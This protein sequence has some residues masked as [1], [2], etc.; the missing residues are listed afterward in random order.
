MSAAL[1]DALP[2]GM[3]LTGT[4]RP[5]RTARVTLTGLDD[6]GPA[7][8][9]LVPLSPGEVPSEEPDV[10]LTVSTIELCRLASNRRTI[11]ELEL[12]VE[13]DRSLVEPVLVGAGAFALD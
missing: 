13:G 1:L 8:T 2:L 3:S 7:P 9:F 11:A 5:G 10:A 12:S 6:A 4:T